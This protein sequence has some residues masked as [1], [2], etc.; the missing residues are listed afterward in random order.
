L[1]K[2]VK[3]Y[4]YLPENDLSF[5]VL[6]L[7][8]Y[9]NK[10]QNC[11]FFITGGTGIIGKWLLE[12]LCFL[13][14]KH[15][16]KINS[17]V[18]TRNK[19]KFLTSYPLFKTCKNL[20]FLEGDVVNFSFPPELKPTYVI[21][22]ATE[23]T[24]QLTKTNP[25]RMFEVIIKGTWNVLEMSKRWQPEGILLLSS[26]AVYGKQ[27]KS[28]F[29]EED[30][31]KVDFNSPFSAYAFGKQGAEHLAQLYIYSYNLPIKIARIFALVGPHL[32]LDG[33]FAIG[34][35]IR[36]VLKGGP[37]VIKGDGRAVRSYL[38]LGDLIIWLLAILFKGEPGVPYNVGS[39]EAISI[40][41]LAELVAKCAEKENI[42]IIIQNTQTFSSANDVYI[43]SIKKA[44]T[45]GL[46]VFTPLE[47][48]IRKTI[49]YYS[50]NLL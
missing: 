26:G 27:N 40:K 30:L 46:K 36:D 3:N 35:F 21:H 42:K 8:K 37:I 12:T 7:K 2:K 29:E 43:P 6:K 10:F 23:S 41:E 39:D 44:H 45:L 34:N 9:L 25:L 32:P 49:F 13:N 1:V 18:L 38:Y 33:H 16:L 14:E 50:K 19:N 28:Y 15:D 47:E 20:V 48:A 22:G 31:G 17:Y 5:I 11:V 24:T 4:L